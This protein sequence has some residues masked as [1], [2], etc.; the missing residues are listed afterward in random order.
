MRPERSVAPCSSRKP[1]VVTLDQRLHRNIVAGS[2]SERDV[3]HR[4]SPNVA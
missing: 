1:T 4:Q 2:W 3:L